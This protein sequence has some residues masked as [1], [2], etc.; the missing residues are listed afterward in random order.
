MSEHQSDDQGERAFYP[1]ARPPE[2]Y[3]RSRN[4]NGAP[5]FIAWGMTLFGGSVVVMLGFILNAVYS[6]NGDLHEVKGQVTALQLQVNQLAERVAVNGAT[7][8]P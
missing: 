4:G 5:S 3:Y 1:T 2:D 7:R 6:T 8:H